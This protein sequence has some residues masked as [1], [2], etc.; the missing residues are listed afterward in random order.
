MKKKFLVLL[1]FISLLVTACSV[2]ESTTRIQQED[3]ETE[4]TSSQKVTIVNAL[5]E[6]AR[7]HYLDALYNQK[8][9]FNQEAIINFDKALTYI[10][11]LSYYPQIDENQAYNE[12][13]SSIVEDYKKLI[14]E[15]DYLPEDIQISALEEWIA[16]NVPDI[17]IPEE[18]ETVPDTV[19]TKDVIVVGDFPLEVNRYV[20]KYIEYFTGKGR[21]HMDVWL[22]RSGKYFPMMG[23]IFAEEEVPQQLIFLSMPESGLNPNARSWARAVGLWQFV[24]G[25]GRLY[26]LKVSF[27]TDERKDPEKAT[28]AAARHLRDLYYSLGDWYLAIAAYNCGEGR[29]RRAMRRSGSDDFWK[30]RAFLPRE[31]RNYVPQYIATT[32]I[33]SNPANYGFTDIQY[34]RPHDFKVHLIENPTDLNVLAKCAGISLETLRDLNPELTQHSTP[35]NLTEGYP[36]KVPSATYEAF[37]DNYSNIPDEAKLQYVMHTIR[38]G[39]TL[40]GISYKYGVRLSDLAKTNNISTNS[41]IYPGKT[42]KI[43]I[44]NLSDLDFALNTDIIPAVEEELQT[45]EEEAPYELIVNINEDDDKYLKL[46][47]ANISDSTKIVIPEDKEA[48]EYTVKRYDNLIDI[49]QIFE[50]RVSDIRNWNNLPYT[51]T[52]KVGQRLN[53]YVPKDQ[54][55]NYANFD[56]LDRTEKMRIMYANSDGMW[57]DHKIR[58]G[59]TLSLIAEKYGV[60]QNQIK[61][62]NNLRTSRIYAGKVLKIFTG[63]GDYYT[64]STPEKS[65]NNSKY[66]S[67]KI[68]RGDV[69]GKIAEKFD[70]TIADLKRWNNISGTKIVAGSYIKIYGSEDASS[71]GD[72]IEKSNSNVINYTIKSGDNLN[73]I[74]KKFKVSTLELMRWNDLKSS[75]I[76][77]GSSLKIFSDVDASKLAFAGS[78]NA[79]TQIKQNSNK[80]HYIV[81]KGD[82]LGHIAEKYN[83][84]ASDIRRWNS[85]QGSRIV[86]GQELII[87]PN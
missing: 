61:E 11:R 41:N 85:I 59:E 49:A 32:L 8:L 75:K 29:V 2:F 77:A 50:V 37:V 24:K 47:E 19:E 9:G 84:R 6:S 74:A 28:R 57:I 82:T 64:A 70:V 72:N 68:R 22:S 5:L 87:Y 36:L 21:K 3:Q 48:V 34:E 26:D 83:I 35:P 31:T 66:T 13:E 18:E 16:Q 17:E 56:N 67:Y 65:D 63:K 12:L 55:E 27:Y 51:T 69:L 46:Y 30:L 76:I 79:D 81:K 42:L 54:V 33:G 60:R 80:L 15:I 45:M 38:T 52:V 4:T 62:W 14:A 53:I 39:E 58:R 10:N 86:V 44:S 23:R 78:N 25:T 20:E 40:S 43:P 71:Y 1:L 7:Q 73:D